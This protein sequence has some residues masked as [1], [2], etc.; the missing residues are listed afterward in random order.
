[1]N[2]LRRQGWT[3]LELL[4]TVAVFGLIAVLVT[5][6]LLT[7]WGGTR[8]RL[9]AAEVASSMHMARRYAIRH[10]AKVGL[11]FDP[12]AAGG[13][14][15]TLYRDGDGDGVL[16]RDIER[17]VDPSVAGGVLRRLA[18]HAWFGFPPGPAPT[19]PSNPRRRLDRLDDPIRFNLS[20]I[21][22]FDPLGTATPGTVYLTD[23]RTRLVAVRVSAYTGRIRVLVYDREREVW[24]AG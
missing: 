24:E 14:S 8:M 10:S 15:W 22:S 20:D 7:A 2:R 17:G 18:S 6:A 21:A 12:D 11:K 3:L 1:M 16:T 13:P 9:A 4:V 5:P 19:N 23:G